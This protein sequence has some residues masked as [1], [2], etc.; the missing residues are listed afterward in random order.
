[1]IRILSKA[2]ID[3][4]VSRRGADRGRGG[5]RPPRPG[6]SSAIATACTIMHARACRYDTPASKF[7]HWMVR[8]AGGRASSMRRTWSCAARSASKTRPRRT[9]YPPVLLV[10]FQAWLTYLAVPAFAAAQSAAP[11]H[12]RVRILLQRLERARAAEQAG[13]GTVCAVTDAQFGAKCDGITD[14]TTALQAAINGCTG[15]VALP[16][17]KTCLSHALSLLNGT[18]LKIPG[19]S[20]LKAFPDPSKWDNRSLY[21]VHAAG[22]HGTAIFG[23]GTIDGSGNEW[24]KV[25]GGN[26]PH[27]FNNNAV[28]NYSIRDVRLINSGR[29]I[30]GFGAP[31]SDVIVDNV[32]ISEPAIGNSDGIDVSCDGFVIQ[33]SLVQN[34]DD[35]ICMKSTAAGSAKNGLIRGCTVKN[36]KQLWPAT[37]NYPG[38]AGGLVLGTA[39]APAMENI[40][41]SNCTVEGALA[42]IRIKFRPSQMGSVKNILFE[43]IRVVNPVVYAIDIIMSSDHISTS[44]PEFVGERTVDLQAVTIRNVEGTLGPVP[45]DVCGIGR[46]CPRAVARF[47]CTS[48]FPC[49][50]MRLEHVHVAGF[51]PYNTTDKGRRVEVEACT[52]N[53]FSA[54]SW[55]DVSPASCAPPS[56]RTLS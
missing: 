27:L 41:Y 50:G 17:G 48:E 37:K 8:S 15:T 49:H 10:L 4:A 25:A 31:C 12:P 55:L 30:L 23:G 52:F 32:S 19:H 14:D 3:T 24:W 20:V 39:V 2:D 53:N 54:A 34:G 38:M 11:L 45:Q 51:K 9:I 33:N 18:Q 6:R 7:E 56:G 21:L 46:I 29:G 42:G 47:S 44:Q 40:T 16:D 28:H 13:G 5:R 36:G 43:N 22:T 26:R 1:M 35:S